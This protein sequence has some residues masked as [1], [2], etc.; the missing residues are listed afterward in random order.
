[1]EDLLIF[2]KN[3]TDYL[4]YVI[5]GIPLYKLALALLVV[6]LSLFLRKFFIL[7]VVRFV[8]RLAKKSSTE[9]DIYL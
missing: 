4:N 9:L 8:E 7:V 5:F 1:M 6:F 3:V 2:L